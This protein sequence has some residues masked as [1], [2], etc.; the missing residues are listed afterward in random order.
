M[1]FSWEEHPLSSLAHCTLSLVYQILRFL[2]ERLVGSELELCEEI[3]GQVPAN[4]ESNCAKNFE[5]GRSRLGM[6]TQKTQLVPMKA[7]SF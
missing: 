3:L 6:R 5:T 4:R 1:T 2:G 7:F